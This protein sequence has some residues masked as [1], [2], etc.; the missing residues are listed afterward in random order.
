MPKETGWNELEAAEKK[1]FRELKVFTTLL[2]RISIGAD[3]KWYAV[4]RQEYNR[5]LSAR[6]AFFLSHQREA[7]A[8]EL[9]GE[10]SR[11]R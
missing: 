5:V 8:V 1:L 3:A 6:V 4:W 9:R 10:I 2:E 7:E 11:G